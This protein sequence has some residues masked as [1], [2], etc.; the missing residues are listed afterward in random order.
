MQATLL[1]LSH[2]ICAYLDLSSQVHFAS[3]CSGL[4]FE[5]CR[6]II[7]NGTTDRT[8]L[9]HLLCIFYKDICERLETMTGQIIPLKT[10][11]WNNTE[12]LFT[13]VFLLGDAKI[14]AFRLNLKINSGLEANTR[15]I[16]DYFHEHGAEALRPLFELVLERT[17]CA[18][19]RKLRETWFYHPSMLDCF[20]ILFSPNLCRICMHEKE[21]TA[22]C[23]FCLSGDCAINMSQDLKKACPVCSERAKVDHIRREKNYLKL[24]R[25]EIRWYCPLK[26]YLC[27][28]YGHEGQ[29]CQCEC[30]EGFC[31][32]G[33]PVCC[34]LDE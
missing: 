26:N 29:G 9:N 17:N 16:V 31:L 34:F 18:S 7:S 3:T 8:F 12:N 23:P 30:H 10:H 19:F 14:D 25:D 4:Q 28:G 6:Y 24:K 13:R 15:T 5:V 21:V 22:L 1:N 33:G 32:M 11:C 27:E 20:A 2:K